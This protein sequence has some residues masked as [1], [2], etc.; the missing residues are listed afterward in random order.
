MSLLLLSYNYPINLQ[1]KQKKKL[2]CQEKNKEKVTEIK[3][4]T[5]YIKMDEK[6]NISI[7]RWI[8]RWSKWWWYW[9]EL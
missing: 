8:L 1:K 5:K 9:L 6:E 7:D 4:Q 2:D 3:E